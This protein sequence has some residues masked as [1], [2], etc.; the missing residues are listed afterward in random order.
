MKRRLCS[1]DVIEVLPQGFVLTDPG[2]EMYF[3]NL[4]CLCVWSIQL[5]TRRNLPDLKKSGA[6]VSK[7]Q[8][9]DEL[10]FGGVRPLADWATRNALEA[11]CPFS[12]HSTGIDRGIR[13][14]SGRLD[15]HQTKR[16]FCG[17]R[18]DSW[19]HR[20]GQNKGLSS[21]ERCAD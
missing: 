21:C 11:S 9:G 4:R 6:Y 12:T 14:L 13:V 8:F 15:G 7:T 19:N 18:A 10:R 20:G 2:G 17:I 1:Y 3:C 16:T 5:A